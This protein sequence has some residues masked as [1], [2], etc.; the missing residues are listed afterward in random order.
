MKQFAVFAFIL[1]T[2]S[3]CVTEKKCRERFPISGET[4]IKDTLI[5][6][7]SRTFDTLIQDVGKDTVFIRDLKTR[8]ET[9]IVRVN[10]SIF[11]S[12]KCPSDTVRVEK[13]IQTIVNNA[14]ERTNWFPVVL[15]IILTTVVFFTYSIFMKLK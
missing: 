1:S 8:I 4:L 15:A 3:A 9:K 10:D 2:L 12:T 7:S 6:T 11:V 13:V 5:V 14:K